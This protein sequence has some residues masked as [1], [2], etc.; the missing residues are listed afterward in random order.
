V[1]E[2]G[3]DPVAADHLSACWLANELDTRTQVPV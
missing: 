2:P 1:E 3:L